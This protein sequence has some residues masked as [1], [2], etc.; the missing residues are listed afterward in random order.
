MSGGRRWRFRAVEFRVLW[1]STG[2]DVLP[3]PLVHRFVTES[4]WEEVVRTRSDTARVVLSQLNEDLESAVTT[5]LAPEA[6]VEVAGFHGR[7]HER[8]IRV[9]GAVRD[10]F[11]AV[12]VQEPGSDDTVGGDVHLLLVPADRVAAAVVAALPK[13]AAGQG[14]PLSIPVE[15]LNRPDPHIRD[16]WVIGPKEQYSRFFDRPTTATVHIAVYPWGSP[17]NR[18]IQGRKDFQVIDFADDGRYATFGDR[19]VTAKP[20]DS[21]R[22]TAQLRQL[23]TRT[24]TEVREGLH[25][26]P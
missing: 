18:H 2:R 17:D 10:R 25:P 12:A 14:K 26:H 5:L 11:G 8:R 7:N 6:R 22:M 13:C 24:L 3:Y 23:L 20:T 19:T 1:D 21:T 9:H 16:P 4:T 15:D